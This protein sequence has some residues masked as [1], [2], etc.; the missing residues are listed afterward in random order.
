[1]NHGGKIYFILAL[2]NHQPVGNLGEVFEQSFARTYEPFIDVLER[3]PGIR[4]ALHYSGS[5]LDWLVEKKPDFIGRL[6]KIAA[7][8]QVEILGGAYYEPIL[9]AIP[10]EDKIGQIR[11]MTTRLQE[12]FGVEPRGMWLAERVWEPHL[13]RPIHQAGIDYLA[14]DDTHFR[15]AGC[16]ELEHY[17]RTEEEGYPLD[18]FPISEELRYLIPFKA[19]GETISFFQEKRDEKE[20]RL[21]VLADDGEKFGGWPGTYESVYEKGWLE[22]FF[23]LLQEQDD[24]INV[25][26]FEEYRRLFPPRGP[27]YLP[28]GSYREM[29]EWSGGFWRNFLSRYPESNR[30]H[31]KMLAV[32]RRWAELQEGEVREHAQRLLWAGQCNCAYWHGVFGGLYLN[33]LRAAVW[34]KLLQAEKIIDDHMKKA[35]YLELQRGDYGYSGAEELYLYTDRLN[36]LL[37]PQ[38]GGS[39]W[40]L[41]WRPA[42]VNF[43][44]TL[45]RRPEAYHQ[46]YLE[47]AAAP[48]PPAEQV[49][50]IHHLR[51]IKEE[52]I[53]DHLSYDPYPR[54]ALIEHFFEESASLEQFGKGSYRE[55]GDFLMQPAEVQIERLSAEEGHSGEGV[56]IT[57]QR[58]GRLNGAAPLLLEKTL[59]VYAGEDSFRVDYHLTNR[60]G[61]EAS[62]CFGVEFNF[63]FLSGLDEERYYIIPG[64]ELE[65][66]SLGSSG[67]V[68]AVREISL[69]DRR[70]NLQLTLSWQQPALL[71]RMP[72]ETISLSEAGLERSYQQSLL[73]PRWDFHLAAGE[74]RDLNLQLHLSGAGNKEPEQTPA[75]GEAGV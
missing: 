56:Q 40:E 24:W 29:K 33:F 35:P 10:D 6:K 71:W 30:M 65:D 52:G 75:R 25:V 73:L 22:E 72:V 28:A 12:L 37:A 69:V 49:D 3:F 18:I 34:Q 38:F 57:F 4:V 60:G 42:A 43:L 27:V 54:G 23:T 67:T 31:K 17:F 61:D 9:P 19:P 21:L 20:Q 50:S 62:L 7:G 15:D 70:R 36:L 5:L 59:T 51:A 16:T 55:C 63:A 44:D 8:G 74:S 32:R 2:H 47:Q 45:T 41:S 58:E 26:T 48:L 68:E 39:L 66:R 46:E 53:L 11:L 64:H 13:P 14:V 1:M